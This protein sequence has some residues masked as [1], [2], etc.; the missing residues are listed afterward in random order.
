MSGTAPYDDLI[1][2]HIKNARNYF[3]LDDVNHKATGSNP[4]CG[5]DLTVYLKIER[6]CIR[7]IA[8]QCTCCGISMAS[9]SI[10]TEMI[11]GKH[12]TDA[13]ILI[14]R[15]VALLHDRTGS[16]L[17]DT[18]REQSAIL[19]TV[20]KFPSRER[21]AALPWATLEGALDNSV[22]KSFHHIVNY[23][24]YIT[25]LNFRYANHCVRKPKMRSK[26]CA[27]RAHASALI[28]RGGRSPRRIPAT[29]CAFQSAMLCRESW[30]T[31]AVW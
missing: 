5:D 30:V 14:Q 9:A 6:D 13:R 31:P 2:D 8:F 4:L 18:S 28:R 1:M 3:T 25:A 22:R 10:M 7:Q 29:C 17:H 23:K 24:S 16:P 20:Q 21:C 19:E 27:K 15:F 26:R 12:T 11:K